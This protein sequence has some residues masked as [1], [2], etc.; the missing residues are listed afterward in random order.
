M[1]RHKSTVLS[2]LLVVFLMGATAQAQGVIL[3]P[4]APQRSPQ[5]KDPTKPTSPQLSPQALQKVE[6]LLRS[7]QAGGQRSGG[8]RG[9]PVAGQRGEVRWY[10]R[11]DT[12][13]S[14]A[15]WTNTA[16]VQRLGLTDDQKAEIERAFENHRLR[17]VSNTELLEKE[18]AQLARLLE[19]EPLDRNAV[20]TQIDHVTQARGEME[21]ENSAM[22]LEMREQ[23]TRTQWM[24][25]QSSPQINL[26]T[27]R[28]FPP[29]TSLQSSSQRTRVGA[30][31][32]AANLISQVAP[33]VPPGI[34]G[35]VVLEAEISREGTVENVTVVSGD[36]QLAQSARDAVKQWRYK[37]TLLNGEP[38]AIIT[39][40]NVSFPFIA[41]ARGAGG[42]GAAPVPSPAG[43]PGQR[44]G[45]GQQ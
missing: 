28:Y 23:L 11:A 42:R 45:P 5:L 35:L 30:N 34:Q 39:T 12:Q 43:G 37:P 44:R 20:L 29:A 31:I 2:V 36:P 16:L 6:D 15:W 17:I 13:L 27:L 32:S 3:S 40:I 1:K 41:G 22:T 9:V 19:A 21:R 38:V 4:Q 7:L 26:Q 24:Q 14:N 33:V 10:T 8:G 25:L 18:E